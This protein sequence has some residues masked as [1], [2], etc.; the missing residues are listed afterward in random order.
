MNR[1]PA[2]AWTRHHA[3]TPQI[4]RTRAIETL[5]GP[6]TPLELHDIA[7]GGR[8]VRMFRHAPRSLRAMC[9]AAVSPLPFLVYE[10]ERFTF[11]EAWQ[12]ASRIAHVLVHGCGVRPG[13]RIAIARR[14]YPEWMLAFS[15]ITSIGAVAVAI[16]SH[17]QSDELAY[18][19]KDCGAT[20]LLA[21]QERLD[22]VAEAA[23]IPGLQ[24]L[25]VRATR[26]PSGAR[27]LE[28]LMEAL[29]DVPMPPATIALDDIAMILYTSG[30]SGHPKGVPSSHRN[31]LAALLPWELDRNI[32][33]LTSGVAPTDPTEQPGTLL[34]VPLFHV[35]GLN[36]SYLSSYR[37]QS[38]VVSMYR[39]DPE[40]AAA[41]IDR[42]RLTSVGGPAAITGD[43]VR[44]AQTGATTWPRCRVSARCCST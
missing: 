34:A 17:W 27:S 24:L 8:T 6:G 40:L 21:D 22:R 39:W 25:A 36:A 7:V 3:C 38:R 26:L 30:S 16:N 33:A 2:T 29:G 1:I 11:A 18:G 20:V 23:P 42:E 31:V 19:P 4:T 9:E 10:E 15:A 12:S 44:I 37:M 35:T 41:L 5:T 13:D 43:L 14:N 32:V 28:A